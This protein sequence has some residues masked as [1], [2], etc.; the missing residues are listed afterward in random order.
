M[1]PLYL[2]LCLLDFVKNKGRMDENVTDEKRDGEFKQK[3]AIWKQRNQNKNSA[4]GNE[5]Q[6]LIDKIYL[7]WSELKIN[8]KEE[9]LGQD[10]KW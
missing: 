1:N 5:T 8:F 3:T 2:I 4:W 10:A 7:R 9:A 6:N